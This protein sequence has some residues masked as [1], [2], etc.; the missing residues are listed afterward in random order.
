[1]LILTRKR[2]QSIVVDGEIEITLLHI[3]GDQVRLGI[4]APKRVAVHRKELLDQVRAE[5]IEAAAVDADQA[6][7]LSAA[8][9]PPSAPDSEGAESPPESS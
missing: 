9:P 6:R 7:D 4:T 3:H 2:G 1:M 8:M 5:N